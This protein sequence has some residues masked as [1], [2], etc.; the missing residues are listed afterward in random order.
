MAP[1]PYT[2]LEGYYVVRGYA[3]DADSIT[4]RAR[5]SAAWHRLDGPRVHHNAA[6]QVRLRLEG[7]DAPESHYGAV[8]Q[9][10]DLAH[11]ATDFVLEQLGITGV[12]WGPKH[13]R[14]VAAR[15]RVPGYVLAR[16][17][18]IN[19]RPVA[20]VF[21]GAAPE[22]HGSTVHLTRPWLRQSVNYRA[23]RQGMAY[24]M[25]YITLYDELREVMADAVYDAWQTQRGLWPRDKSHGVR[26]VGDALFEEWSVFPRLFRRI[27]DHLRRRGTIRGL[28]RHLARRTDLVLKLRTG[29]LT[30]FD[31]LISQRG[32]RIAL[33]ESPEELVFF[34]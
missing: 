15:D 12:R 10:L 29:Q 23:L 16:Q 27:A 22:P 17:T 21:A 3:P 34:E 26:V 2:L 32:E 31:A 24:P 4:F 8:H 1:M 30:T 7:I 20:F 9:P 13:R 19:G 11:R 6:W 18:D 5:R 28:K 33:T 25:F 14:V